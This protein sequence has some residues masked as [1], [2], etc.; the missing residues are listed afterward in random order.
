MHLNAKILADP[1]VWLGRTL[2]AYGS[3]HML[4]D[5]ANHDDKWPLETRWTASGRG[6]DSG[7]KEEKRKKV[8]QLNATSRHFRV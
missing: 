6:V 5:Q 7:E 3:G 4:G 2:G 1:A 8:V